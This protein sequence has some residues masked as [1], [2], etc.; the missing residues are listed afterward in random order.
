MS[1]SP[2]GAPG[3]GAHRPLQH[4]ARRARPPPGWRS[5]APLPG[6]P[7]QILP[8]PNA[9]LSPTPAGLPGARHGVVAFRP[10]GGC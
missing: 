8:V 1:G 10:G 9:I 5:S 7:A 3:Q 6:Q 4:P 2:D